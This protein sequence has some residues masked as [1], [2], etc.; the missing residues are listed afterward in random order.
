MR[1]VIP[2]IRTVE[3]S[4]IVGCIPKRL[5]NLVGPIVTMDGGVRDRLEG[6]SWI[7]QF[8]TNNDDCCCTWFVP[9]SLLP[10]SSPFPPPPPLA[11]FN[12]WIVVGPLLV[13]PTSWRHTGHISG[14]PVPEST[15]ICQHVESKMCPQRSNLIG[16]SS[17]PIVGMPKLSTRFSFWFLLFSVV[18]IEA[19]SPSG[20]FFSGVQSNGSRQIGH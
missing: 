19:A 12:L 7:S 9:S 6:E 2:S 1:S 15:H 10:A 20:A 3:D 14:F 18:S 17:L 16:L 5:T 11:L 8:L 4:P 13:R